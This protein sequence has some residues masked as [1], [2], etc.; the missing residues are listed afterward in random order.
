MTRIDDA[1][2]RRIAAVIVDEVDPEQVILFGSR[3]RGDAGTDSD[4]DLIVVEAEPFGEGR[5]RRA[6][7]VRLWRALAGFRVAKDI[8]VYSSDERSSTGATPSTTCSRAPCA[9][10]RCSMS[11]LKQARALLAA[12]ERDVSA[13]GGMGDAAVFA[14]EIFGFHVQQAAEKLFKAWIALS[15]GIYPTIHD[16]AELLEMLTAREPDAARFGALIDYTPYAVQLRYADA[17]AAPLDRANAL[18]QVEML[19]DDVRRRL[20]SPGDS[21]ETVRAERD[22]TP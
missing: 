18:G 1:L 17:D 12:A 9:R 20:R 16:L 11:D 14:D 22:G 3:A 5:D 4:V 15:G 8:L 6:E 7:A 13:L 21:G 19:L 2:L 10:A